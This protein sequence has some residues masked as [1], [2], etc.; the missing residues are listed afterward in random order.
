MY[1]K[2]TFV[3]TLLAVLYCS[4]IPAQPPTVT[5]ENSQEVIVSANNAKLFC[6][7]IGKGSPL[8]VIHG[9][10]GLSQDYL[11]PQLNALAANHFVIFYDQRACGRSTGNISPETINMATYLN[12][13]E[14]V[15]K[16]FNLDKVSILGHSWG[17]FLGMQYAIAYPGSIEKLILSNSMSASSDEYYIFVME[18]LR[19]VAP[20]Q[21]EINKLKNAPE[22]LA[23]DPD[24]NEQ[25]NRI[26]FRTYCYLPE[27]ADLLNIKLS[28]TAILNGE[29]VREY[30]RKEIFEKCFDLY[31]ALKKLKVPTLIIHGDADPILSSAAENI[32]LSIPGSKYIL[33]EHCGHFP[34]VEVP[35]TYFKHIN[36]FLKDVKL[37]TIYEN[38]SSK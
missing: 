14:A 29:K 13:I 20:F 12:D 35:E 4:Y 21:N 27:K 3:F 9:G 36:D 2:F 1:K 38:R 6:R 18:W 32:H 24:I 25:Y 33:M 22:F 30:M 28:K 11:L 34:Y 19:R 15:R 31:P 16:H 5:L 26:I 8:I 17:G 10:P 7:T 37:A 23:G